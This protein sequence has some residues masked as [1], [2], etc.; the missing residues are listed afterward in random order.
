[1][2][3]SDNTTYQFQ[4][5]NKARSAGYFIRYIVSLALFLAAVSVLIITNMNVALVI[6]IV[7]AIVYF[8]LFHL[9]RP[10]YFELLVTENELT[11]NYYSV[12]S[13]LKSYQTIVI[14]RTLFRGFE[15][16]KKNRGLTRQ[17]VLTVHSKFGLAD[18]PPVSV[19]IL[20]KSEL[21]QVVTVLRKLLGQPI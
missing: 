14:E 16:R 15:I 1:M 21:N 19:S 18:Y 4:L 13:A 6:T 8:I 12:A 9:M 20:S 11:I 5:N 17:L 2:N 7:V 10:S 3:E